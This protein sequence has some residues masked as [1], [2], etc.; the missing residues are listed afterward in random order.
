M[1]WL[2][3]VSLKIC[4]STKTL[5][6]LIRL[7]K[8]SRGGT[9]IFCPSSCLFCEKDENWTTGHCFS[10]QRATQGWRGH[11]NHG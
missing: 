3:W 10:S 9:F 4:T 2:N 1:K 7:P 8:S 5:E 6:L 11:Y